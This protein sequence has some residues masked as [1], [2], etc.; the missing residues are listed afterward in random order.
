MQDNPYLLHLG[1]QC[2]DRQFLSEYCRMPA[3]PL[4]VRNDVRLLAGENLQRVVPQ[5][6]SSQLASHHHLLSCPQLMED[7][8]QL[9]V[10]ENGY[11]IKVITVDH[12][13]HGVDEPHDVASIEAKLK[14]LEAQT[15]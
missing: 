13:A 8:E 5:L 7:L 4:M 10:L 11:K 1:L 14:E 2:Y 15:Q 6:Q 9:K 3:T 12:C